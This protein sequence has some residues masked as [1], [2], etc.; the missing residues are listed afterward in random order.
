MCLHFA[1]ETWKAID[2]LEE[3]GIPGYSRPQ[4]M[5]AENIGLLTP[6][7]HSVCMCIWL[8]FVYSVCVCVW[9]V[10]ICGM[11]LGV[12]CICGMCVI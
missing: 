2:L 3:K 1:K 4:N 8:C 10:S 9:L 5:F 11:W 12:E 7:Y 6:S